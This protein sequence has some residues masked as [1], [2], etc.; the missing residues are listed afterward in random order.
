MESRREMSEATATSTAA[1]ATKTGTPNVTVPGTTAESAVE[2]P[3]AVAERARVLLDEVDDALA[4]LEAGTFG[5]CEACGEPI[6]DQRLLETPTAR[7]CDRHPQL[8]DRD[9]PS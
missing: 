1:S 5:R 7:T 6:D 4:R 2:D 3:E 9:L 8:T